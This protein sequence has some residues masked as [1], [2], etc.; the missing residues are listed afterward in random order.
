MN[1]KRIVLVMMAL[2]VAVSMWI[3]FNQATTVRSQGEFRTYLPVV[4]KVEPAPQIVCDEFS[5]LHTD[6]VNNK[7]DVTN[8]WYQR[9]MKC[10]AFANDGRIYN[11]KYETA[12]TEYPTFSTDKWLI[13][14]QKNGSYYSSYFELDPNYPHD[15]VP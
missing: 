10:K 4:M 14:T 9:V 13:I 12:S 5:C 1:A 11:W 7:I 3:I 8:E 15:L 2:L 6:T